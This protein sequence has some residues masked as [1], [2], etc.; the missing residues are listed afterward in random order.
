MMSPNLR[1]EM[2]SYCT[3]IR[4]A[5]GMFAATL[6][7]GCSQPQI[8]I[9]PCLLGQ[10]LAFQILDAPRFFFSVTPKISSILVQEAWGDPAWQTEIP[11]KASGETANVKPRTR[12][13]LYG[14]A[15]PGW[16][17]TVKPIMLERGR[18]YFAIFESD[19]GHGLL[20]M[21]A[22]AAFGTCKTA[23]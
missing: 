19:T 21:T 22:G 18:K 9:E 6:L 1:A 15:L 10:T 16:Q 23:V 2:L 14:Q 17:I 11:R 12:I 3:K 7:G 4:L 20:E 5:T 13:I 8:T